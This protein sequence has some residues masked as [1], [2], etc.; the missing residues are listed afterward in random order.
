MAGKLFGCAKL[1]RVGVIKDDNDDEALLHSDFGGG[2]GDDRTRD[3]YNWRE[4]DSL[5]SYLRLK[6]VCKNLSPF[7][8]K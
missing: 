1:C 8:K 6:I 4:G 2:G 5:R 3:S 7:Y